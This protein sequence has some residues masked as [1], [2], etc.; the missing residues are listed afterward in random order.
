LVGFEGYYP[1]QMA[2]DSRSAETPAVVVN[3]G[4]WRNSQENSAC[5]VKAKPYM[6]LSS[7][8]PGVFA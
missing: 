2:I 4:R 3:Q 7:W 8:R 5:A 1:A 6:T